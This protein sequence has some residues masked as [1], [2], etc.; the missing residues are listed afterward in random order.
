MTTAHSP[1]PASRR[2]TDLVAFGPPAAGAVLFV[3]LSLE[4]HLRLFDD[5]LEELVDRGVPVHLLA[6]EPPFEPDAL[7]WL[8]RMRGR[9]GFTFE[10]RNVW[11]EEPYLKLARSLR[12]AVD[13]LRVLRPEFVGRDYFHRRSVRHAHPAAVALGRS[14][15]RHSRRVLSVATAVF[16]ALER[17]AP[18]GDRLVR[19]LEE[20]R[21]AALVVCP[22]LFA[23]ST[24]VLW[25]QASRSVGVPSALAIAS[26]DNLASKQEIRPAPDRVIVWNGVQRDEA[27]GIHGLSGSSVVVT[28]AQCFDRWFGWQPSSRADFCERSGIDPSRPFVLFVGGSH[29]PLPR[30]E[31]DWFG[32]WLEALRVSGDPSL[33][34][35]QV[36]VRPHPKRTD[37]WASFDPAAH[38]DVVCWPRPPVPTPTGDESRRDYYDSLFHSAAVVGLNTSAMVEAAIV[39]RPVYGVRVPEFADIQDRMFHFRYLVEVGGGVLQMADSLSEHHAQLADGI[40]HGDRGRG[41]R[42]VEG[43]VRPFG[44]DHVATPIFADAVADLRGLAS[45]PSADPFGRRVVRLL[46]VRAA[47]QGI[48]SRR[49]KRRRERREAR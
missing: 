19:Y 14:P 9:D 15:L 28:G 30:T 5:A 8:E 46:L 12:G 36:L 3:L 48:R 27:I 32:D 40:R 7:A 22:H 13:H 10:A 33:R 21:P 1:D 44:I 41:R 34:L 31:A 11:R 47:E 26:W 45:T 43:F 18:V 25:V 6:E 24:H 37:E 29:P 20:C 23:G 42:F 39:G 35:V 4:R 49:R 16:S 38:D 2:P 17:A